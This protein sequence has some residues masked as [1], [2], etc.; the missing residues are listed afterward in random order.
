MM[1]SK[2]INLEEMKKDPGVLTKETVEEII[3]PYR[4]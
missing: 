4:G 2:S 3:K 1:E